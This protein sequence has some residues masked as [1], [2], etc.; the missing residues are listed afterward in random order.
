MCVFEN[1]IS[2]DA[3]VKLKILSLNVCGLISK[4]CNPD[5]ISYLGLYDIICL[6]ETK[7]DQY[8]D[9]SLVGYKLLP[10]V[11]RSNCKSRSGG[12]CVF[13]RD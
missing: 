4:L 1:K 13:V 12:I 9:V 6:T 3:P 11:N 2:Y 5:F 8:D 10:L 7:L